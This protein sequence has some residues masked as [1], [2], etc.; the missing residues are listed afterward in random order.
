MESA[1]NVVREAGRRKLSVLQNSAAAASAHLGPA[2]GGL[3]V[4]REV[5]V[6]GIPALPKHTTKTAPTNLQPPNDHETYPHHPPLRDRPHLRPATLRAS[7][8]RLDGV[9][10]KFARKTIDEETEAPRDNKALSPS[11]RKNLQEANA[12]FSYQKGEGTWSGN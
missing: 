4:A 7:E 2:A 10:R 12:I 8:H 6:A 9:C 11:C 3:S 1:R 5:V